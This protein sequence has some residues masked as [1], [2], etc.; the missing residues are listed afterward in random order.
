MHKLNQKGA[1]NPLLV[2]LILAVIL[3]LTASGLAVYY[4]SQY[5]EQKDNNQPL[6]DAAVV[7]AEEK[8]QDKLEAEFVEREKQPNK[9]YTSP[10]EFG[11]IRLQFPKTWSSYVEAKGD[12]LEYYGH[13][14]Y[15]PAAGVNYAL[16]M[17]VNAKDFA[18]EVKSYDSAVKKGELKATAIQV[19]GITGTRL[20]GLLKKDQQGSMVIFPLRDKVLK[21]WT[22]NADFKGDYD[23]IVLKSLTFVP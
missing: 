9:T 18:Q 2:P 6:I 8:L 4:Y 12:D 21:V 5:I 7:T 14:N 11:S 20:D 1:I 3:L 17:S 13:P 15:V 22:E 23:N 19:A 16:R 10:S